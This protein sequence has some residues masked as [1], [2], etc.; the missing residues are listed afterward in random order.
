MRV[1]LKHSCTQQ[2]HMIQESCLDF[3]NCAASL[4]L[5]V[6]C[7]LALGLVGWWG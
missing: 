1:F 6:V 3:N 2:P 4:E 5:G 7:A